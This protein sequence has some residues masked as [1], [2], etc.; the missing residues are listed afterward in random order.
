MGSQ[1]GGSQ[2]KEESRHF[3]NISQWRCLGMRVAMWSHRAPLKA[4]LQF[5]LDSCPDGWF[6]HSHRWEERLKGVMLSP[7]LNMVVITRGTKNVIVSPTSQ[8]GTGGSTDIW[9]GFPVSP[10]SPRACLKREP[11]ILSWRDELWAGALR[12]RRWVEWYDSQTFWT[13]TVAGPQI[14]EA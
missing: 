10:A 12:K 7:S 5:H 11:F 3:S 6:T 8:P 13:G 9:R 1:R 14:G 2:G 4:L